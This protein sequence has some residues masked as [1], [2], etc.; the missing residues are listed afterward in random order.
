M[1]FINKT[2]I[3]AIL[4]KLWEKNDGS[5]SIERISYNKALQDVQCEIGTLEVKEVDFVKELYTFS[6]KHNLM[7]KDIEFSDIEKTASFFFQLGLKTQK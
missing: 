2:R 7:D 3:K 1:E 4:K 5:V 6:E